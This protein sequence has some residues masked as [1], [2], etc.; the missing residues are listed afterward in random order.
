MYRQQSPPQ[1]LHVDQVSARCCR[2]ASCLLRVSLR[3]RLVL[4]IA[5][6]LDGF[7]AAVRVAVVIKEAAESELVE[8]VFRVLAVAEPA[9]E[10]VVVVVLAVAVVAPQF[11]GVHWVEVGGV[12]GVGDGGDVG[13]HLLPQVTGEVDGFEEGMS[14]YF[15]CTVLTEAVLWAS[16]QFD[17]EI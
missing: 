15:V 10:G 2:A 1:T 12:C 5:L 8:R 13:R 11:I 17:Y 9:V 6:V 3:V 16:A 14:F 4:V 7:G